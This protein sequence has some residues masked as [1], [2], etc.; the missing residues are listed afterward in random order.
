[1]HSKTTKMPLIQ[2]E[3]NKKTKKTGICW[4]FTGACNIS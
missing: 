1:M 4:V 3:N 2:K